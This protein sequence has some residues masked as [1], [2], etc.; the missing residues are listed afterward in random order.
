MRCLTLAFLVLAMNT[1][2]AQT[3][4]VSDSLAKSLNGAFSSVYEKVAP[5]VVIIEVG[6]A[7]G[8]QLSGLPE[9]LQFFW[10]GPAP[11][12]LESEQGSG[13]IISSQGHVLTNFH[14]VDEAV[15]GQI[16]VSLKDGRKL[17]AEIVGIDPSTDLAV[18]KIE[19]QDLPA[20]DLGDSDTVKVGQF[21]FA[22]GAPFDLPYTF[23]V[24]IV[25]AKGRGDLEAGSG[26]VAEYIQTD[27]SI[28]PGNSGGPLCD[29]DGKVIGINTMIAGM[30]RGLGFA[31]P[32]NTAKDVATQLIT[33][34]RVAR[35]WLGIVIT[36][37]DED[38]RAKAYFPN[39]SGVLVDEIGPNT[40]A[41][42]SDLRAGD[43]ITKVD[44]VPV[45]KA[46]ELRREILNKKVG[47]EVKLDLV[48]GGQEMVVAVKTGEQP[49]RMIQASNRVSP[50]ITVLPD[51]A[52]PG[53]PPGVLAP[54]PGEQTPAPRK[55]EIKPQPEN[56]HGMVL[57]D[58]GGRLGRSGGALVKDVVE[59]SS[60]ATAG[61][62]PG[63]IITEAAGKPVHS[64]GEL[65]SILGQSDMSRGVMMMVER[66]NQQTFVILKP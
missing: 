36:G 22:L 53:I 24:G 6:K 25:S 65:S 17:D 39:L 10:Q 1:L 64:A 3:S 41:Y 34:G 60:A 38:D 16:K 14:V 58:T 59:E 9:G 44:G 31:L 33:T 19:G 5:S 30:N 50:Q 29:I 11:K 66:R 4:A 37:V 45:T 20:A 28:N 47:Q 46:R 32:I 8:R 54:Q 57:S 56:L 51:P 23:T 55:K 12:S 40:P 52:L 13:I 27:A 18:L 42:G 35:S 63:D 61:L 43:V 2:P 15:A 62:L 26:S 21:A 48:R 49:S 7:P